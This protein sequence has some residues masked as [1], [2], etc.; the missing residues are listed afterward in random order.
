MSSGIANTPATARPEISISWYT[1]AGVSGRS[2]NV[3]PNTAP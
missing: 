3:C 2:A 1:L